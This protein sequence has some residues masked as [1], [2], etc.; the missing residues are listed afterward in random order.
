M[1]PEGHTES[2]WRWLEGQHVS[3]WV[4]SQWSSGNISFP[5]CPASMCAEQCVHRGTASVSDGVCGGFAGCALT[6]RNHFSCL[7]NVL[8]VT[9]PLQRYLHCWKL[10]LHPAP[11]AFLPCLLT[12][13]RVAVTCTSERWLCALLFEPWGWP[14]FTCPSA[15][16]GGGLLF[17]SGSSRQLLNPWNVSHLQRVRGPLTDEEEAHVGCEPFRRGRKGAN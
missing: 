2:G 1:Y 14:T 4:C 12:L 13:F 15:R 16:A 9:G 17:L 7:S 6:F 11:C 8:G 3:A 10:F 5:G